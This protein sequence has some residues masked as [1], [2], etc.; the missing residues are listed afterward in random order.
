MVDV[1]FMI[2]PLNPATAG[3]L[4][5]LKKGGELLFFASRFTF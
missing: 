3:F 4:P 2:P 1:N 5:L